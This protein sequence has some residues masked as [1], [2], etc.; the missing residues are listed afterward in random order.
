M[1]SIGGNVLMKGKSCDLLPRLT[2]YKS[3]HVRDKIPVWRIE[4]SG[5]IFKLGFHKGLFMKK[6]RINER[7]PEPE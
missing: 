6:K 5:W 3:L 1:D 7:L 4:T 2:L